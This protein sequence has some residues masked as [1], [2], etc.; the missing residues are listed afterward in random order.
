MRFYLRPLL[1]SLC[2]A[3][4]GTV[5][6]PRYRDTSKLELPPNLQAGRQSIQQEADDE[7]VIGERSGQKGLGGALVNMSVSEPPE[8]KLKQPFNV[9]WNTLASAF[10]QSQLEIKDRDRDRGVY[11]VVFDPDDYVPEDESLLD[12]MGNILA[13]DYSKAVY[14]LTLTAEDGETK[15]TAAKAGNAEQGGLSAAMDEDE[16]PGGAERLL[17]LLYQSLRDDWVERE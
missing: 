13:D 5:E 6:D 14:V 15:I 1:I 9:A 3:S 8:L 4:C 12:R 17:S 2:L 10:R 16:K 11:Y 7:G